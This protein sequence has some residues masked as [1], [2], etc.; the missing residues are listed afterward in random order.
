MLQHHDGGRFAGAEDISIQLKLCVSRLK[1]INCNSYDEIEA[2]LGVK[3][4]SACCILTIARDAAGNEDINDLLETLSP[5]STSTGCPP[6]VA[7][8]SLA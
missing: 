1:I 7:N 3:A 5:K 4:S 2:K 6:K 8:G